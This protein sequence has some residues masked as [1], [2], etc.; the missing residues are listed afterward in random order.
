MATVECLKDFTLIV[1]E[2]APC[3]IDA[4]AHVTPLRVS[5]YA[6]GIW[7]TITKGA[8][9]G[10]AF[11]NCGQTE[12]DGVFNAV[13]GPGNWIYYPTS[14]ATPI[15]KSI[16]TWRAGIKMYNDN[17]EAYGN[18]TGCGFVFQ[19]ILYDCIPLPGPTLW[20]G[21]KGYGNT[22]L[23]VYTKISGCATTPSELTITT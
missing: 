5:G 6:A 18:D 11:N 19:I 7:G 15:D 12:W 2:S 16:Q 20:K 3:N 14:S 10:S 1:R 9:C 21:I 13:D 22:F 17:T 4:F 23:G 8:L